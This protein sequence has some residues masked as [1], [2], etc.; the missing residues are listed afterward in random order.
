M[1][2]LRPALCAFAVA[3][4]ALVAAPAPYDPGKPLPEP[5]LFGEGVLSTGDFESH[6]A[7]APDGKTLYFV[8][9]DPGFTRW[10]IYVSRHA[11]GRW[12]AAE[13]APFSGKHRDADPFVTADGKR[14]YF[15]SDRPV[16]G[17]ARTDMDIWVMD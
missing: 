4:V 5:V 10:T 16:E 7:F 8:K 15:I 2:L 13:V 1:T 17:K 11:D 3:A 14:L 6:P 9:S 12:S